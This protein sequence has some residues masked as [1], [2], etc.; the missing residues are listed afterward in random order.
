VYARVAKW[1]GGAPEATRAA[2]EQINS[3]SADGPPEG[4]PAKGLLMLLDAESGDS[5]SIVLF[6]SEEDMRKGDETLNAMDPTGGEDVGRRTS[7]QMYEVVAD[8]KA[9]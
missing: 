3:N 4:L 8:L 7:V 1:E 9:P 2:A 5:L 6:E